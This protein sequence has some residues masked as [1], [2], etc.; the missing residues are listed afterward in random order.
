MAPDMSFSTASLGHLVDDGASDSDDYSSISEDMHIGASSRPQLPL[1]LSNNSI[2]KSLPSRWPG[3]IVS[4]RFAPSH[5]SQ[6]ARPHQAGD[7][8]Q[9]ASSYSPR[10]Q[11][12]PPSPLPPR[13]PPLPPRPRPPPPPPPPLTRPVSG[14]LLQP[15]DW[16][17]RWR[18]NL[19]EPQNGHDDRSH[20][21][22]RDSFFSSSWHESNEQEVEAKEESEYVQHLTE[23]YFGLQ[24]QR[25]VL[26]NIFEEAK[27]RGAYVRKLQQSEDEA[28][29]KFMAAIRALLPDG[30][31][32]DQ[33]QQLFKALQDIHL[34]YQEAGHRFQETVDELYQGQEDLG[35]REEAFYKAVTRASGIALFSLNNEQDGHSDNGEDWFLRG[36]T[37][38]R[39]ETIHP[40]YEKLKAAFAELQL[41]RELLV[42][43]QMKREALYARKIQPLTEDSLGLLETYGDA[44]K[45]KALEL[46]AMALITEE[47]N[48]QL[49]QYD[50]LE[51]QAERDIEIYTK[52][53]RILQ[54]ECKKNGALPSSSHFQQEG[55]GVDSFYRDEIRLASGPFESHDESATLA[56]PVFPLLL[57]NPTHLLH[58]FPQTAR[59]SL[60]MALQLPLDA[61]V[62]AKQVKE[63]AHEANMHSLLSTVESEDKSEYI[64][65]WLLHK[66]HHSALEAELLWTT[67]RSRMKIL[68]IDRWQ[69]DVL[70][71]WW[72]DKPVNVTSG[73]IGDN[74]TNKAVGSNAEFNMLSW[75]DSGQLDGF[76][77]WNL[78]D[79]WL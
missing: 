13:P 14:T 60:R 50:E 41:A 53:V 71:F 69:R 18:S 56:H 73:D 22:D 8:H 10:P 58:D 6:S 17:D 75:S 66:L 49:Q 79:S 7:Y 52:M 47:D 48:E 76:R 64:N 23:N 78:D 31:E 43:T 37:G 30:A 27:S 32:L 35:S 11:P 77:N 44:G 1:I 42:N 40:L 9:R 21:N 61:P 5:R 2:S 28:S 51:Q 4:R 68:D 57:S 12:H 39:S 67:F 19:A 34:K 59:Q 72:R 65:R 74:E 26:L 55:F 36:I 29:R 46:R 15:L 45:K 16:H 54:Q 62:R 20:G 3:G 70:N 38:D 63:A 24:R 33:L 25:S